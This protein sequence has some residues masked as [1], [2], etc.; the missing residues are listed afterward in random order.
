MVMADA[1][2]Q[3]LSQAGLV[4]AMGSTADSRNCSLKPN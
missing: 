4:A 2:A 3:Q 1:S